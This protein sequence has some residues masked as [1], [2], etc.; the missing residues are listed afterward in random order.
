MKSIT[1]REMFSELISKDTLKQIVSS[2]YGFTKPLQQEKEMPKKKDS[3][4]ETI[5]RVNSKY[6]KNPNNNRKEG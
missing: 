5:Q 2:W 1:R 4:L 3:L 6:V